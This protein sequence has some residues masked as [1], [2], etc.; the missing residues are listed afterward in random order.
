[1]K[2]IYIE[3][4]PPSELLDEIEAELLSLNWETKRTARHEYFMADK[5][6]NYSYG[7]QDDG[8]TYTS[9]PWSPK[10]ESLKN[11]YLSCDSLPLRDN[12]KLIG[13]N[14]CFLN[15]YDDQHQH[16]GWHADDF[17]G[18]DPAAPIAVMSFGA[19][20][21]IWIKPKQEDCPTCNWTGRGFGNCGEHGCVNGKRPVRGVVPPEDRYLLQRGSLFIMP[22]GFQEV[23]LH[24]IPKHPQPCGWR[25]SLT[26][27][28]FL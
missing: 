21:E 3:P 25:I 20:R 4:F 26:F 22:P 8:I 9:K 5:E 24:R 27:R 10:V 17:E 15:K 16:L 2:P 28:K 6:T 23:M 7:R 12:L 11:L 13:C 1:M 19:E 18:M 14:G